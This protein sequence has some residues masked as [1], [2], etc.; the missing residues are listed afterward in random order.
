[1]IPVG[2]MEPVGMA[3]SKVNARFKHNAESSVIPKVSLAN[4]SHFCVSKTPF[5]TNGDQEE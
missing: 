5:R 3:R 4:F 2:E 1:M